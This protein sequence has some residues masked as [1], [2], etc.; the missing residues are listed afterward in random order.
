MPVARVHESMVENAVYELT[1]TKVENTDAV[2]LVDPVR[3][4]LK[5]TRMSLGGRS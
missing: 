1:V 5:T 4:M 3:R 2:L